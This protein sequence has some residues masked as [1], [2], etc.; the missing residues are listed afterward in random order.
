MTATEIHTGEEGN[1]L[2]AAV[3]ADGRLTD[4]YVDRRDRPDG[5][6]AIILG[7]V[8][9]LVE[10]LDVAFVTLDDGTEG[11]LPASSVRPA[12]PGKRI[13]QILRS[14][15]GILVQI[16]T[17][18][19]G[20]K[21]PVL[22]MDVSLP[23]R[24]LVHL[25]LGEGVTVSRR[26]KDEG[27]D[28]RPLKDMLSGLEGGWIL[29]VSSLS[30]PLPQVEAEARALSVRAKGISGQTGSAPRLLISAPGPAERAALDHGVQAHIVKNSNMDFSEILS[31]LQDK[32]VPLPRDGSL[33]IERTEALTAID[34]NGGEAGNAMAVNLEAAAEV[35]RQIRLRNLSGIIVV[36]FLN[37]KTVAH[38]KK[39]VEKLREAVAGDPAGCHVWG[40]T[41]LG[42]VEMTRTRRGPSLQDI[43]GDRL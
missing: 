18:G 13:G 36:D 38:R 9:R 28:V 20:D 23:G 43:A 31:A 19:Q 7:R 42:L 32:K 3:L 21:A 11:M 27:V 6:G 5:T 15:Q 26:L 1:I 33:F 16:K 4:L 10:G 8:S 41:A 14:G 25:P 22:T 40:I 30:V 34:V 24:F 37:M 35:A 2:Y 29:R 39:L 17:S 12:E